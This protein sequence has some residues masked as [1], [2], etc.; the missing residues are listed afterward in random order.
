MNEC[1]DAHESVRT[2]TRASIH[3]AEHACLL[4]WARV[5]PYVPTHALACVPVCERGPYMAVF[6]SRPLMTSRKQ[7][8]GT[9]TTHLAVAVHCSSGRPLRSVSTAAPSLPI[10]VSLFLPPFLSLPLPA[11]P[12]SLPTSS[13][14]VPSSLYSSGN[15]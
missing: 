2:L 13:S 7:L 15:K 8:G 14:S 4:T 12:L 10:T 6:C 5:R 11:L 3:N 9:F 1:N